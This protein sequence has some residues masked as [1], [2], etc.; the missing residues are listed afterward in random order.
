MEKN[1]PSKVSRGSSAIDGN[2]AY[3]ASRGSTSVYK[4]EWDTD[5]WDQLPS[6]PN[7]NSG[8]VVINGELT[9]V[10]GWSGSRTNTLVTLREKEW[11]KEY[12]PMS[13]S[14]SDPATVITPGNYIIVVG[15]FVGRW[16]SAVELLNLQRRQWFKLQDL[17]QPLPYP[18][19]VLHDDQ[20]HVIG[21]GSH[22]YRRSLPEL[23]STNPKVSVLQSRT[24][25]WVALPLLPVEHATTA[26]LCGQVVIVGGSRGSSAVSS[27]HQLVDG[28]WAEVGTMAGG[29]RSCLVAN[30]SPD[31]II[32]V[33]GLDWLF[34]L[35]T[36]EK[37]TITEE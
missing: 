8:L 18:S 24:T 7:R 35:S 13:V 3:F 34:S 21:E 23:T 15:G 32:I 37:C 2:F 36:V 9:A 12:P 6:C 25:T 19:A 10:G 30:R 20:M 33:G 4:Y 26:N 5:E 27:I 28:Q 31:E 17:P 16:C 1:A 29:R 11:V 22:G 14:R